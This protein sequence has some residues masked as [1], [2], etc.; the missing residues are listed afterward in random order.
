MKL[1]YSLSI[2]LSLLFYSSSFAQ[3]QM[4]LMNDTLISNNEYEFD[5]F[6]KSSSDKINLTSYQ[7]VLTFNDL[8]SQGGVLTLSYI[9]GSSQLSN[10][11]NINVGIIE[12]VANQKNFVAGSNHGS[13]TISF[14]NVKVGTFKVTSS[15]P[16]DN[17]S[18]NIGWDF[19]GYVGTEININDTNKTNPSNHI[20]S[21]T[22]SILPVEL[23]SFTAGLSNSSINLRWTTQTELNNYGFEIERGT[24]NSTFIKIGFI[25][26]NGT[27]TLPHNYSFVDNNISGSSK[28]LYRLKQIDVGGHFN[29]SKEIEVEVIPEHFVLYQ[30]FPNP[31][32]PS[33]TIRFDLPKAAEVNLSVYD[34]LGQKITTLVNGYLESG[35]HSEVFDGKNL[36]SG[37]Y[38][39]KLQAHNFV[40]TKKMILMK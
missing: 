35:T 2:I 13:D 4:S 33:T 36:A 18:L 28:F 23:S 5:V 8:V 11:P 6:I 27:T 9:S 40:Q 24:N 3:Y 16:F 15:N 17:L 1:I 12:D 32:N 26:G 37:T 19:N 25:K 34:S 20:N 38:I 29:Y 21:L 10:I 14:V 30:N 31:F 22:N 39:Y 7:I